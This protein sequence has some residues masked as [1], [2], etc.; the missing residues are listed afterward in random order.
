MNQRRRGARAEDIACEHLKARGYEIVERNVRIGRGEIDIVA[1]IGD[2]TAF[3]EV[4][5]RSTG[6]FGTPAEGVT[7]EKIRRI[8]DAATHYA[9]A[10][11]ILDEKLR[12]DIIELAG[13]KIRHIEGAFDATDASV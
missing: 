10:R 7:R 8:L 2:T 3:V 1:K 4:K 6:R 11:G 9:A 12:F 5:S 13:G